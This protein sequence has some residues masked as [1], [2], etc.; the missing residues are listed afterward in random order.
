L[1]AKRPGEAFR[2]EGLATI[3]GLLAAIS[4]GNAGH[5]SV[6]VRLPN[7]M[8]VSFAGVMTLIE[9]GG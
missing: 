8:L 9:I 2:S 3:V 4:I 6:F 1:Q 5:L 7:G